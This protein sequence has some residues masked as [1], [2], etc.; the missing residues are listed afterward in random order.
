[1]EVKFEAKWC[2]IVPNNFCLGWCWVGTSVWMKVGAG[3]VQ[4]WP[5]VAT[6]S[7]AVANCVNILF[8]IND[9]IQCDH[10][11]TVYSQIFWHISQNNCVS[12]HIST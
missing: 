4:F 6:G 2:Q 3:T 7:S 8:K 1:M 11:N 5:S 12:Y 9:I 10:S